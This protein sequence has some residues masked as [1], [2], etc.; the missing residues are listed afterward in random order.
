M[1]ALVIVSHSA[2]L[3]RSAARL[4]AAVSGASIPI[5]HAGGVGENRGELGTDAT[6][7]AQ[8][9]ERVFSPDGVVVL[10]DLGSALLSAETALEFLDPDRVPLVRLCGAPLVE[11]AV[12][13]ATHIA[14]GGSIDRVAAE[15]LQSL[16]AKRIQLGDPVESTAEP[17]VAKRADHRHGLGSGTPAQ[18]ADS[19]ALRLSRRYT[20]N[21][22][23]GLH[24]RPA[25][26]FV[27]AAAAGS[28][29]VRVWNLSNTT[30]PVNG[31]SL[32]S[33]ASLGVQQGHRIE[34]EVCG[35]DA[36]SVLT[37]IST[38][39]DTNFGEPAAAGAPAA[40]YAAGGTAAPLEPSAEELSHNG[41]IGISPGYAVGPAFRLDP[42]EVS[43]GDSAADNPDA[44]AARWKEARIRTRIGI[45][46]QAAVLRGRNAGSEAEIFDAHQ[47]IVDD[48]EL[49]T[50]VLRLIHEKSWCAEYAWWQA[51]QAT[52]ARYHQLD[53]RYQQQR[54]SDVLDVGR[55]L[56]AEL[57]GNQPAPVP[58]SRVVVVADELSPSQTA[59][60]P[61]RHILALVTR[62]GGPSSH[63][64][65]LARALGIPAVTG[66][67][68]IDRIRNDQQ[69][70]VD[71]T[72]GEVVIA[73]DRKTVKRFAALQREWT[74]TQ[75]GAREHAREPAVTTDGRRIEVFA[76]LADAATATQL[77]EQGAEGVGLLRT[78]FMF[79]T[80]TQQP[81]EDEQ[82]AAIEA[83]SRALDGRPLTVRTLDIGGDKQ[84]AYLSLEHEQN[85]FL[86]VRGIRLC[87]EQPELFLPQLRAILRAANSG[88]VSVMIPMVSRIEEIVQVRRALAAAH[89]ELEARSVEHRWPLPL[90]IMIETPAAV[91][92]ADKMAAACDFFSIGSNDLTQYIMAA[93]RGNE[94]LHT[95]ADPLHP[96]VLRAISRTRQAADNAGIPCSVCGEMA[97]TA[98]GAAA[99]IGLGIRKLSMNGPAIAGIKAHIRTLHAADLEAAA[100]R[101]LDTVSADQAR[102]EFAATDP[103]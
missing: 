53:D 24:A 28:T 64:A 38:L 45:Q 48:P 2:D 86:G 13:A 50:A 23:H 21:T 20:I 12:A 99:L 30:G 83:V 93:E 52:A 7:I 71:G 78:E 47:L 26:R 101:G 54:A 34:V 58:H 76:N 60:L 8:A 55:V 44:E 31:R 4:A 61:T 103:S 88:A 89:A 42:E 94:R 73:P 36:E 69:V 82:T 32:N 67:R 19:G 9:I 59:A 5:A 17:A 92:L 39:V 62:I 43:V 41:P 57:R 91:L 74:R 1:V 77:L 40:E 90:G 18:T 80:G 79:L 87:L 6:E 85:P 22:V 49:E 97:T 100:A 75:T 3:A 29:E 37:A 65:I 84:P 81:S 11:G 96:A 68:D 72:S 27:R 33:V 14:A 63:S 46:E 102:R 70:A 98:E 16:S 95:V 25:A 66:F 10:M 51:I 56:L 15:A 35:P